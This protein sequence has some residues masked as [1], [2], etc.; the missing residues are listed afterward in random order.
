[1]L[2]VIAL[3][4]GAC[5][6]DAAVPFDTRELHP[7]DAHIFLLPSS[8]PDGVERELYRNTTYHDHD[9]KYDRH[10]TEHLVQLRLEAPGY[11][12]QVVSVRLTNRLRIA[13]S[14][15]PTSPASR[16]SPTLLALIGTATVVIFSCMALGI[17]SRRSIAAVRDVPMETALARTDPN[18]PWIGRRLG[19][20]E[21]THKLGSGGMATVYAAERR[22]GNGPAK[23]AIKLLSP[24]LSEPEFGARFRREARVAMEFDHPGLMR[25]YECGEQDGR[26]YLVMEYV[27]G[28]TLQEKLRPGG[29]PLPEALAYLQA[30]VSA[31]DAAHR[32]GIVHRDLK[33]ENIMVGPQGVKVM[34]FGLAK[35]NDFSRVTQTGT[36]LGTP[37]YIA[38][39]QIMEGALDARSDQY[40]LGIIG[41]ELLSGR[42]PFD[43]TDPMALMMK[44]LSEEPPHPI[45]EL[46]PD[47]PP[48]VAAAI[49]KMMAKVPEERFDSLAEVLAALGPPP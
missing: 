46:R 6:N 23:V 22:E 38:P 37:A 36:V 1:L 14:L 11:A 27:E 28:T 49:A 29:L 19:A 48:P 5:A 10:S 43:E 17:R 20:Y 2:L 39:E 9:F 13:A 3:A 35:G 4:V 18:D 40:S 25:V 44:H 31:V 45:E 24:Q 32:K 42:L 8:N 41:Y 7:S 34:D 47:V 33:P 30:I 26:L 16:L 21:I 15:N 12:A